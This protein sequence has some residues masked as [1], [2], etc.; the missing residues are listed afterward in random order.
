MTSRHGNV[1]ASVLFLTLF[2]FLLACNS[3]GGGGGD[4]SSWL[5]GTWK[6]TPAIN[7]SSQVTYMT[8]SSSG[9]YKT[10]ETRLPNRC[11]P[12]STG[13]TW[14]LDGNQLTLSGLGGET[15]TITVYRVDNNHFYW[16]TDGRWNFYRQ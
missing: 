10:C 5:V 2:F 6:G 1:G 13:A 9:E 4:S 16:I 3:G 7:N 11:T 12:K 8:F 14:S 15:L